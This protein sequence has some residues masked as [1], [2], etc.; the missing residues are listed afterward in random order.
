[1]GWQYIAGFFDGEGTISHNGKGFRLSIPQT[2]K[3]V[4]I[5][6]RSFT[7][8]GTI[9][10]VIKRKSHWKDSWIY[11]VAKQE[12]LYRFLRH[13]LPF[14]IVKRSKILTVLPKLQF[15]IKL[16]YERKNRHKLRLIKALRFRKQGLSYWR[17]GREMNLDRSY[18][19]RLILSKW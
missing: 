9:C 17:I 8:F 3:T 7:S 18:V 10:K 5:D 19:R 14:T 15:I 12:E 13:I 11:Y 6:I 4:L 16:Q 2:S 1:M